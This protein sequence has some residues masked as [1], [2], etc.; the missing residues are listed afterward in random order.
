L[1][2]EFRWKG[3]VHEYFGGVP[4]SQRAVLPGAYFQEDGKSGEALA[5]KL[6]RDQELLEAEVAS[7][8]K[9][10]RGWLYLARTLEA[11]GEDEASINAYL[12]CAYTAK[13]KDEAAWAH[14]KA[15][16]GF[17]KHRQYPRGLQLC[18][19]GRKKRPL[20]E[21]AWLAGH[22]C[23]E[24]GRDAVWPS[25]GSGSPSSAWNCIRRKRG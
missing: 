6:T 21:L 23:L 18:I 3:P 25:C 12:R 13:W 19:L 4:R 10:S 2:T 24:M 1:P 5:H 17:H 7:H 8:P 9:N 11:Q 16:C 15:A 22:C 14:Y 20:P